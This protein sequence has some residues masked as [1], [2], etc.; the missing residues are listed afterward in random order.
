MKTYFPRCY[1]D[2]PIQLS[3]SLS[4]AKYPYNEHWQ[5]L[6]CPVDPNKPI[7]IQ[8]ANDFHFRLS[9]QQFNALALAFATP[10]AIRS[11][12]LHR[13]AAIERE[14]ASPTVTLFEALKDDTLRIF[15]KP[16]L[17]KRR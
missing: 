16:L 14:S 8:K 5:F 15:L 9:L 10:S 2:S 11:T 13:L 6:S 17:F 3:L 4:S 1:D 7:S 12:A